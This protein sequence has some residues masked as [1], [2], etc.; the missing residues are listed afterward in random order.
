M[1]PEQACGGKTDQRSDVFSL[2]VIFYEMVSGDRPFTGSTRPEVFA[3]LLRESPRNLDDLRP[4]VPR[5]LSRLVA[6]CL[7]KDPER[8]I[9][10]CKDVRNELEEFRRLSEEGGG[11]LWGDRR[12]ANPGPEEEALHPYHGPPANTLRALAPASGPPHDVPR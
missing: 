3:A 1:S 10:T 4:D 7:E 5:L 11:R 9:Q 2:G 12:C 8:R 6:R